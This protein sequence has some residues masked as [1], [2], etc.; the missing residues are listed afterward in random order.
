M[1]NLP[2]DINN[3]N[4]HQIIKLFL[5]ETYKNNE[6]IIIFHRLISH[7]LILLFYVP[8]MKDR[9]QLDSTLNIEPQY[10]FC[11]KI[12]WDIQQMVENVLI[13]LLHSMS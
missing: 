13:T 7:F 1:Q 3:L 11:Y 4:K 8:N 10:N 6:N 9:C 2:I 5:V 12:L